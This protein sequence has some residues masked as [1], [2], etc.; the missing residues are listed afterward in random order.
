MCDITLSVTG[1]KDLVMTIMPEFGVATNLTALHTA[2]EVSE[3]AKY[4]LIE[5]AIEQLFAEMSNN[6]LDHKL[7]FKK[8]IACALDAK[9][10]VLISPDNMS[11]IL[12]LT[13]AQGG[14]PI[15]YSDVVQ[16]FKS[17][18]IVKGVSKEKVQR[19]INKG[20]LTSAGDATS[21]EVALGGSCQP[22]VDGFIEYLVEDPINKVLCPKEGANGKVDM[23][24][25][26]GVV[27]V[28]KGTKLARLIRPTAGVD[29]FTVTGKIIKAK[30]GKEGFIEEA[31]GS[32][33]IDKEKTTLV[34]NKSGMPKHLD[35]S[36]AV[37]NLL[38][39][40]NIDVSTG[41]IR[42]DGAIF[43]KGDVCEKMQLFATGDIIIGGCVESAQVKSKGDICINQG[44]I[45]HQTVGDNGEPE[46]S[47]TIHAKGGISAQFVQYTDMV[48]QGKISIVQYISH[49]Q[50][51]VEG[52]LWVGDRSKTIADGKLFG[53]YIQSG[54]SIFVGTL[55]SP[56][57]DTTSIDLNYWSE[58]LTELR[59]NT[60]EKVELILTR[61][62]KISELIKKLT[63][64][65]SKDEALLLRLD[66][67]LKQHFALL[68]QFNTNI[69]RNEIKAATHLD[70]LSISAYQGILTGVDITIAD[71]SH[72]LK[73]DHDATSVYWRNKKIALEPIVTHAVE[74][75]ERH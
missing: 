32:Y 74:L 27:Y 7:R 10:S 31:E 2:F 24:E 49:C 17:S 47:T 54:G 4:A 38:E 73:R 28:A 12:K 29:G 36:V 58:K 67:S 19:L 23:R 51:I 55:G 59:H 13:A 11:A 46:N 75:E 43:V 40:E 56:C 25:L 52:E 20:L 18:G 41:N 63:N 8:I 9:L 48:S 15:C 70:E 5:E 37:N 33:F 39:I 71:S 26:G 53:S 65:N 35:K 57:G 14:S 62:G 64:E 68:L 44:I 61:S 45:G 69:M 3:F 60:Q 21:M 42:F 50:I 72:C 16:C 34:A 6:T 22:G 30:A 66:N 1:N